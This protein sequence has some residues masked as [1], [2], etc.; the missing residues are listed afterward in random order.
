MT[1]YY[2][3]GYSSVRLNASAH[4]EFIKA[5]YDVLAMEIKTLFSDKFVSPHGHQRKSDILNIV[6]DSDLKKIASIAKQGDIA[7]RQTLLGGCTKKGFCAYGGIDNIA[8]C[9]GGDGKGPCTDAL[10]DAS[11]RNTIIE[12]SE[13][14]RDRL[15][16]APNPSPL[17]DSLDAQKRAVENAI[18][19]ID[20]YEVN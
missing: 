7:W 6:K 18:R 10:F 8:R 5:M 16:N 14:I 17:R 15:I 13:I 1:L 20:S 12:F 4:E 2:G 3:R 11:K 9:A 19:I